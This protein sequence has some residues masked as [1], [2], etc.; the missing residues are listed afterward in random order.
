[1]SRFWG[2]FF[3]ASVLWGAV[4]AYLFVVVGF[5]PPAPVAIETADAGVQD[6]GPEEEEPPARR[7][8]RRRR[9]PRRARQAAETPTGTATVGDDLREDEMRTLDM[10][11][12]GGEAQLSNAQV[13]AG[14]DSV[15]GRIRRCL[16]L[17]EGNDPVRG[18]LTFGM[19]IASTGRVEAVRLSG[20]RAATT[21]EAGSCLQS[22]ARGIR[23]DAFD[24]P[25][26]VVRYPLTLE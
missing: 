7:R 23:F 21:G 16:V 26:M 9:R 14:F 13:E 25:T 15:M 4:G 19:R 20:P 6:A 1:M 5:A 12:S 17:I 8:R 24:G 18:R 3:A 2:G 10:N 22:T 11:G